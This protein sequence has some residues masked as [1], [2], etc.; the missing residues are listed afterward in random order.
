MP[1]ALSEINPNECMDGCPGWPDCGGLCA[2]LE[3]NNHERQNSQR[4]AG[5]HGADRD[6]G[7]PCITLD[8]DAILAERRQQRQRPQAGDNE[9]LISFIVDC[10]ALARH[11][12]N[13]IRVPGTVGTEA[14]DAMERV[15]NAINAFFATEEPRQILPVAEECAWC[16][17]RI[18]NDED[19]HPTTCPICGDRLCSDDCLQGHMD[20]AHPDHDICDN[21]GLIYSINSPIIAHCDIC[22]LRFCSPSCR[23]DHIRAVHDQLPPPPAAVP[24][25][26]EPA[27]RGVL[28]L[29]DQEDL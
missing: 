19:H 24:N 29:D 7:R 5:I 6:G 3:E 14:R 1:A 9:A 16:T 18:V 21:C 23:D 26:F 28:D 2:H 20:C 22:G 12:R 13:L 4:T 8:V 11:I 17:E 25:P 27:D 15:R 10:D